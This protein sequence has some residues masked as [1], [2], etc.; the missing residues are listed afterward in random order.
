MNNFVV[1]SRSFV[2]F[3]PGF[4]SSRGLRFTILHEDPIAKIEMASLVV[5]NVEGSGDLRIGSYLSQ[6]KLKINLKPSKKDA[7]NTISC[8]KRIIKSIKDIIVF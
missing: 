7:K 6:N 1:V 4:E 8:Y 2:S 3:Y 5:E